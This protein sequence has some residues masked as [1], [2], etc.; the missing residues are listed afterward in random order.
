[1]SLPLALFCWRWWLWCCLQQLE[2]VGFQQWRNGF[3]HKLR[4]DCAEPLE[5]ACQSQVLLRNAAFQ[6]L[7]DNLM[8]LKACTQQL[9]ALLSCT[10]T[11]T[12]PPTEF[13][14]SVGDMILKS[15]CPVCFI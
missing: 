15:R 7:C 4:V 2:A 1:M 13:L 8:E 6:P 9:K 3:F 10:T 11:R 5:Q 12:K 14:H